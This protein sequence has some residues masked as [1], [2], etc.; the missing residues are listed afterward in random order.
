MILNWSTV[1]TIAVRQQVQSVWYTVC[2]GLWVRRGSNGKCHLKETWRIESRIG[3]N[4]LNTHGL[5]SHIPMYT[6]SNRYAIELFLDFDGG[7][8]YWRIQVWA[9]Y[10]ERSQYST[11]KALYSGKRIPFDF[12]YAKTL[13]DQ[14]LNEQNFPMVAL[15]AKRVV[16]NANDIDTL[17]QFLNIS[18][19]DESISELYSTS[20]E[21]STRTVTEKIKF[22]GN[23]MIYIHGIQFYRF[24]VIHQNPQD[25]TA[26]IATWDNVATYQLAL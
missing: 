7:V 6:T 16:F 11:L 23:L 15:V 17:K 25:I 20:C 24:S 22:F 19:I 4:V 13:I 12:D 14:Y 10:Y 1:P 18:S 9:C 3:N 5:S 2:H 21:C 8:F 26:E